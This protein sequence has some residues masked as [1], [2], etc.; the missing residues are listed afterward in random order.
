MAY[1]IIKVVNGNFS[2]HAEGIADVNVAKVSFHNLC[3]AL[4]NEPTVSTAC[5][6]IAD[7]NLD[8]VQGYKEF[9]SK[10]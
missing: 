7:E 9:V 2:V 5:V 6:M 8:A 4:W 1:S 10:S 3:A